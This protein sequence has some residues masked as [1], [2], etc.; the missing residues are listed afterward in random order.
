MGVSPVRSGYKIFSSE[1]PAASPPRNR[2]RKA[3]TVAEALEDQPGR[4][5]ALVLALIDGIA[6]AATRQAASGVT[7]QLR[8]ETRNAVRALLSKGDA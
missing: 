2:L 3:A 7:P 8:A 6:S 5:P 4:D 1:R